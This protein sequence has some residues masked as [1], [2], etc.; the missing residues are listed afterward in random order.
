MREFGSR[1]EY[2]VRQIFPGP[3]CKFRGI[4]TNTPK[5]A[6]GPSPGRETVRSPFSFYFHRTV[7]PKASFL[8]KSCPAFSISIAAGVGCWSDRSLIW[9]DRTAAGSHPQL[10]VTPYASLFLSL[11]AESLLMSEYTAPGLSISCIICRRG[12][13]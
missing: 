7:C 11:H 13:K 4:L 2:K 6:V 3:F 12:K 8:F 5:N 9:P 1:P 10:W